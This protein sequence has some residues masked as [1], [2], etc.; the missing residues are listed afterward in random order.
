MNSEFLPVIIAIII[1]FCFFLIIRI[2]V[3]KVFTSEFRVKSNVQ[4]SFENLCDELETFYHVSRL[5]SKII[6]KTTKINDFITD[7]YLEVEFKNKDDPKIIIIRYRRKIKI[8]GY[9]IILLGLSLC[10]IGVLLPYIQIQ[11]TK[12]TGIAEMDRIK[13]IIKS[14]HN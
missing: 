3:N 2:T 8:V 7:G 6:L 13:S 11:E 5:R 1:W 14:I 4:N 9:L 12:K 10:Y